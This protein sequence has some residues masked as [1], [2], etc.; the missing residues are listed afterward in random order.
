MSAAMT[1]ARWPSI[2]QKDL[3]I[4][5]LDQYRD[6]PSMLPLI[7]RFKDAEQ[8]TE[9]DLEVGDT[10]NVPEFTGEITYDDVQEGYK[11]S[12]SEREYA[13]GMKVTRRLLRN[14]LYG[15]IQDRTRL[16]ADS[17]RA[18]RETSGA[19]VFNNAFTTFTVGD[20]LSLCNA[21]HTSKYAGVGTQSNAG[22][23]AFS[24]VNLFATQ[25]LFKKFKTNRD[26]VMYNIPDTLIIPMDLEE[27]AYE[28]ISAS[29]KVDTQLNNRNYHEGK[30]KCIVWDN[31]LNSSSAW[32]FVNSKM[33]KQ[34]LIFREW[35]PVQFFRSGEFDSLVLKMAGYCSYEKSTVE[36]RWVYGNN[37][38]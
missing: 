14:D 29:G 28:I 38:S 1:A 15:V 10:G 31:F 32:F 36:W 7:F 35:E 12:V 2:V 16:L 3:S 20:G 13:Y 25:L 37:P 26:N 9:H 27:K 34:K 21:S 6:F 5:F 22:S 18:L 11:K 4:C 23:L 19:A 33:M 30:Y 8:A 24:A 17:F